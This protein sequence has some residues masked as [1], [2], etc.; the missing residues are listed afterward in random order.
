MLAPSTEEGSPP[1]RPRGNAWPRD[2][3]SGDHGAPLGTAAELRH[4]RQDEPDVERRYAV[5]WE[6]LQLGWRAGE[7]FTPSPVGTLT[8]T[9]EGIRRD[10]YGEGALAA[11]K[12]AAGLEA[13]STL[14]LPPTCRRAAWLIGL[15]EGLRRTL[16]PDYPP[17]PDL[18]SKYNVEGQRPFSRMGPPG[19]FKAL[20]GPTM[21]PPKK[22]AKGTKKGGPPPPLW[23]EGLLWLP[24]FPGRSG[25]RGA[26]GAVRR[27]RPP[28]L[29]RMR[30]RSLA[31]CPRSPRSRSAPR[32]PT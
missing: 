27:L 3:A 25:A 22:A 29:L 6:G 14:H 13:N 5:F 9:K 4:W 17:S 23:K 1:P 30:L 12:T 8:T 28:G 2:P 26:R 32:A 19:Q 21:A 18:P 15:E 31:S 7:A 11:F 24:D 10:S 16:W 20:M